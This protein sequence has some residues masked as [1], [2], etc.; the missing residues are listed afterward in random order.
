MCNAACVAFVAAALP[1]D[2][3]AG[4][5]VLEIGSR[6]VNGSVRTLIEPYAGSYVG[7]DVVAGPG[8]D[9]VVPAERLVDEFGPEGFDIVVST[10]MLEHVK[11]W[12]S[13]VSNMK[14]VLVPG[15]RLVLTTRSDG[16]PYHG[17]PH[18]YWRYDVDD[19]ARIFADLHIET[20]EPDTSEPG[21]FIIATRP[22]SFTEIDLA[23]VAVVSVITDR[24][25]AR[26]VPLGRWVYHARKQSPTWVRTLY[27]NA[28]RLRA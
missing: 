21:V 24:R 20:L 6:D 14:R 18:D 28:R 9:R 1:P 7:V 15:G 17:Y 25:R 3:V 8:V 13:A 27:R 2:A 19:F 26:P 4:R 12:R 23:D 16:F 10:E 22:A 11:D 5:G